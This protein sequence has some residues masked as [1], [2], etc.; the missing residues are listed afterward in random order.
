MEVGKVH[1]MCTSSRLLEHRDPSTVI[2]IE[3]MQMPSL[4]I[5][6]LGIEMQ[7]AEPAPPPRTLRW[8][9]FQGVPDL[10]LSLPL[11][12]PWTGQNQTTQAQA[13]NP[14][15]SGPASHESLQP[16]IFGNFLW[17]SRSRESETN[18]LSTGPLGAFSPYPLS[19][20]HSAWLHWSTEQVG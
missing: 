12:R 18:P 10:R 8:Q 9:F 19:I 2:L 13:V 7:S 4:H 20:Y 16:K 5:P 6:A 11:F 17:V 14:E 15:N 3:E 1:H